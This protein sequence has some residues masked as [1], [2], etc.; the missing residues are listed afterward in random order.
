MS[1]DALTAQLHRPE[2][3]AQPMGEV[4]MEPEAIPEPPPPSPEEVLARRALIAKVRDYLRTFPSK[5]ED[6]ADPERYPVE[7]MSLTDLKLMI[8]EMRLSLGTRNSIG[9]VTTGAVKTLAVAGHIAVNYTPLKVQGITTVLAS[10]EEWTDTLKE[11][12]LE[13]GG[14]E[15]LSPW[16][17]CA[18]ITGMAFLQVHQMNSMVPATAKNS[19]VKKELEERFAEL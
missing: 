3:E 1:Y 16:K 10:N 19:A 12:A 18:L 8:D 9:L 17:R 6:F 11:M 13:S 7:D 2:T 15:F 14:L 4:S 5:L